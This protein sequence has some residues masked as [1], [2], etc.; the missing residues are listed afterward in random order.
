M[1]GLT[2]ALSK[3]LQA[4]GGLALGRARTRDVP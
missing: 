1:P 3:D 2:W 4:S